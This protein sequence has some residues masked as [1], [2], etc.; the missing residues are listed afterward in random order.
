MLRIIRTFSTIH[1]WLF[2]ITFKSQDAA[3]ELSFLTRCGLDDSG[4]NG[5]HDAKT[6]LAIQIAGKESKISYKSH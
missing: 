4:H 5:Q 1:T 6:Q 2:V 3:K